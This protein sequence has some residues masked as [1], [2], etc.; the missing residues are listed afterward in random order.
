MSWDWQVFCQDTMDREVV[1]SCFGKGGDI[2]YLDWMLSAWGWTVFCLLAPAAWL[3]TWLPLSRPALWRV[4]RAIV[5]ATARLTATRINVRG[6]EHL[7]DRHDVG[8]DRGT[9]GAA[10]RIEAAGGARDIE[11]F[12]ADA[13]VDVAVEIDGDEVE[14]VRGAD[15]RLGCDG[16][17][18]VFLDR[19]LRMSGVS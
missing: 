5:R 9:V 11:Q 7:P 10:A 8:G 14:V 2:T 3:V 12:G 6:L 18:M 17:E 15:E 1:Q 16:H 13:L 19:T 4:V